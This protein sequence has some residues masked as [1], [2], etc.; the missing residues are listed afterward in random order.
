MGVCGENLITFDFI[1][2]LNLLLVKKI[3]DLQY[4]VK[5]EVMNRLG[6]D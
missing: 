3:G 2:K 5:E 1:S 4:G 6:I